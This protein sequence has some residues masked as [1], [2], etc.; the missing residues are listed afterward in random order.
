MRPIT[1]DI[2]RALAYLEGQRGRWYSARSLAERIGTAL[3][4]LREHLER[5]VAEGRV[6][7]MRYQG[8]VYYRWPSDPVPAHRD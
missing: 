1:I 4:P 8:L 7:S 5:L 3:G 2:R 6:E